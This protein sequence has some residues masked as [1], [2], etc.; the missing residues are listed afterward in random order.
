MALIC[1]HGIGT[2]PLLWPEKW[3]S[4]EPVSASVN[5]SCT[6]YNTI[7]W[8]D[9]LASVTTLVVVTCKGERN[10]DSSST[11]VRRNCVFISNIQ[12]L[13][14]DPTNTCWK[15][16]LTVVCKYSTKPYSVLSPL[17][18]LHHIASHVFS[19]ISSTTYS[20]VL[21]SQYSL[22]LHTPHL[23]LSFISF[24]KLQ[25]FFSVPLSTLV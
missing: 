25:T 5:L 17:S 15:I 2:Y 13:Q 19:L 18:S 7:N 14:I 10:V 8:K 21:S 11:R 9:F 22:Y 20:S 23:V 6:V 4:W 12:S 16:K 3:N 1:F 24:W